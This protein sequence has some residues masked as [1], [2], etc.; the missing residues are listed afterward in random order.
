MECQFILKDK[1]NFTLSDFFKGRGSFGCVIKAKR[2]NE[3]MF[4][5]SLD[6]ITVEY[7]EENVI[8]AIE[9]G[10]WLIK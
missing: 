2:I 10:L 9:S 7:S 5:V 3:N 8:Y 1:F 4:E 6:E